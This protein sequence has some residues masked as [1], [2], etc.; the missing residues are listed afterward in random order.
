MA[1]AYFITQAWTFGN[2]N[3]L[4]LIN[5]VPEN[6]KQEF[7]CSLNFLNNEQIFKNSLIGTQKYLF[8]SN[9]KLKEQAIKK[10]NR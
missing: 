9:P 1:M 5:H 4:D 6:E 3:F 7:D 10:L 8:K 2:T